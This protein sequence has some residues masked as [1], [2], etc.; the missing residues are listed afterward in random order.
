MGFFDRFLKKKSAP[1]ESGSAVDSPDEADSAPNPER[2]AARPKGRSAHDWAMLLALNSLILVASVS[3]LASRA[4]RHLTENEAPIEAKATPPKSAPKAPIKE[5]PKTEAPKPEPA[6]A[7]PPAQPKG[8]LPKPSL[9]A[10]SPQ[11]AE[12]APRS[13]SAA[14][15]TVQS[16]KPRVS[17]PVSFKHQAADAKEVDL[18]GMFLVRSGG[19]KRMFK[20]SKGFWR[21]TVYLNTGQSYDYKFEIVEANGRKTTT[22]TQTVTVP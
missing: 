11:R 10:T 7:D 3:V 21:S 4:Y 8:P 20:D 22:A 18:L 19:R 12:P 9:A 5:D 2:E 16:E 17:L 15:P 1:A 6:K 14:V 13:G